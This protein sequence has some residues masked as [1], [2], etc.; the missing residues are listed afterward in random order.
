[1]PVI[2]SPSVSQNMI[3]RV[4]PRCLRKTLNAARP[5][6]GVCTSFV[7]VTVNF[8]GKVTPGNLILSFTRQ[9]NRSRRCKSLHRPGFYSL[10]QFLTTTSIAEIRL[11]T[12]GHLSEH[13]PAKC[14]RT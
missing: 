3:L 12:T 8:P 5:P 14:D 2:S 10:I 9:L 13:A 1:M 6:Q 4:I 7:R 11:K